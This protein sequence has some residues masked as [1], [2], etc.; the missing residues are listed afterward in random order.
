MSPQLNILKTGGESEIRTHGRLAPSPVFKTGALSQLDHLSV[1]MP[2][3]Y[4]IAFQ[5]CQGKNKI[6]SVISSRDN[7]RLQKQSDLSLKI[8]YSLLNSRIGLFTI[9]IFRLGRIYT[10]AENRETVKQKFCRKIN[11]HSNCQ[12][13][14][15]IIP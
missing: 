5:P 1:F 2:K 6:S 14:I 7:P 15:F 9:Q 4:T 3:Y 12:D 8:A 11:N 13:Q 10:F